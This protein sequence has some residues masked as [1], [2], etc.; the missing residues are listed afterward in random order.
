MGSIACGSPPPGDRVHATYNSQSGRLEKLAVDAAKD[1]K[2]DIFSYMNGTKFVRIEI[3]QDEDGRIDRWEY[4]GAD[5]TVERVGRSTRRDGRMNRTEFYQQGQLVRIE[6]D[7]D[8]DGRIDK[9]ETYRDGALATAAFD[10]AGSGKADRV[11]DYSAS[12]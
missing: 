6:T 4:Y 11:I 12:K 10:T 1:G 8:G 7:T 9:W 2:P 5:Q 3:D